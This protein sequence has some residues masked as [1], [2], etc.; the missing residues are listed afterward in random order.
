MEMTTDKMEFKDYQVDWLNQFKDPNEPIVGLYGDRNSGRTTFGI[1]MVLSVM[2]SW[3]NS[4]CVIIARND[5]M[6]AHIKRLCLDFFC[7]IGL[8]LELNRNTK[9]D[10]GLSNGSRLFLV[11][12]NF[13]LSRLC[14]MSLDAA[15]MDC[16][17][18][19]KEDAE[20]RFTLKTRMKKNGKIIISRDL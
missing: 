12:Q 3:V 4:A 11:N 19:F 14:G 7:D 6:K 15:F 18:P 2:L 20:L 8:N 9:D 17:L 10:I 1:G 5:N 13:Y 16:D